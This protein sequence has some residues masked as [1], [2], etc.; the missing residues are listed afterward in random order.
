[1]ENLKIRVMNE[2]ESKEAQELFFELGGSWYDLKTDIR[3]V[4]YVEKSLFL[5][6]G[7]VTYGGWESYSYHC[8]QEITLP[9]LRDKVVLHRNDVRDA[10]HTDQDDWKWFVASDGKAYVFAAGNAENKQRWDESQLDHVDLK[11]IN[12]SKSKV[13]VENLISGKDALIALAN[14]EEV[15]WNAGNNNWIDASHKNSIDLYLDTDGAY[16]FRLKPRTIKIGDVEVPAPFDAKHS[17][18]GVFYLNDTFPCG[19]GFMQLDESDDTFTMGAWRTESEIKQV[20]AALR[21]LMG[22]AK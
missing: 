15:Q 8:G 22:A 1:M 21:K 11:P 6:D 5:K 19:Y 13:D 18:G 2:Q 12:K 3:E 17:D 7:W 20:V 10:N 16:G 9:Q 14:G 4:P